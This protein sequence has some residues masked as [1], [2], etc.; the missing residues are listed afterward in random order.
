MAKLLALIYGE[1]LDRDLP[2]DELSERNWGW[3]PPVTNPLAVGSADRWLM[4]YANSGMPGWITLSSAFSVTGSIRSMFIIDRWIDLLVKVMCP[5]SAN[6]D[7][8]E[9]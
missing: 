8:R 1:V 9:S 5:C 2:E 6:R 3:R 7:H 4:S